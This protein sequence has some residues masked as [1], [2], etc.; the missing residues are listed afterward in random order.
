MTELY[1]PRLLSERRGRVLLLTFSNPSARNAMHPD[2][3]RSAYA[4]FKATAHDPDI[5]A[6]VLRGDG[7]HFCGGGDLRRLQQQRHL[8]PHTQAEH[9]DALHEW[10]C[11][12]RDCPQPVIAAAE[13]A[14]AGGGFS[15]ALGCDLLVAAADARFAMSYVRI[16]LSPDGGGSDVLAKALPPQL[17]LELLLDGDT[18]SA[19]RL[20]ALGFVNRVTQPGDAVA[21][22]LA[23]AARLA[24]G[25]RQAQQRIKQLVHA[26]RGRGHREQ[27]D[28]ERDA[29]VASLYGQ[30]C[31]EG[32]DAF[33]NK[34]TP[35]FH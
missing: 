12:M 5:G 1:T 15:V 31:G 35:R 22:A 29:F 30:E 23:W 27:L 34:R 7:A 4:I 28:A 19:Q 6:V 25:P 26:A 17:A 13:G 32:I 18:C 11:A 16:G 14:V 9:L 2:M 8:P 20:H 3:Y 33:L 24:D 21:T 10:I